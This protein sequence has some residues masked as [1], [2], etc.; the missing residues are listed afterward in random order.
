MFP[1]SG[2][3][4]R[5]F[6]SLSRLPSG[7]WFA[8]RLVSPVGPARIAVLWSAVTPVVRFDGSL[9]SLLDTVNRPPSLRNSH[10]SSG[11]N[12]GPGALKA[13][14]PCT[15]VRSR[16]RQVS[17]VPRG[18][19]LGWHVFEP[20]PSL[21]ARP[22]SGDVVVDRLKPRMGDHHFGAQSPHTPHRCLR[23]AVALAGRPR[24]TRYR[25]PASVTGWV[26]LPLGSSRRFLVTSCSQSS[27]SEMEDH[28]GGFQPT[29]INRKNRNKSR[30][31]D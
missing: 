21:A 10:G 30:R 8:P 13:V 24:K 9:C 6:P 11:H 29:E 3:V 26:W 20:R 19:R 14:P 22:Y 5:H 27:F 28:S 7:C 25:P 23:F 1:R 4:S 2:S 18:T 15:A 17:P 16:T 31:D 12:P